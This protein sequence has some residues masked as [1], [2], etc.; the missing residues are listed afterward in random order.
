MIYYFEGGAAMQ[1]KKILCLVLLLAVLLLTGCAVRTAD[2]MYQLPKRS[3]DFNNLQSAIDLAMAGLEYCAPL[4]GENRQT[5]QMADLDGNGDMEYLLFAKGSAERPLR[6]LV[7]DEVM[8]SFQ[9]IDT[10]E[11]MGS[12]FDLV[13]YVQMDDKPGVEMVVGSLLS[14]QVLR[15]VSVY[16]FSHKKAEMLMSANY[17]KFLTIDLDGDDRSE[18]FVLRPGQG[19]TDNGV[20]ELY[21]MEDGTMERSNEVNM[22]EPVDH[23]KRIVI[24]KLYGGEPAVYAASTVGDT[25]LITDVFALR[26]EMLA[27]ISFSNESGTSVQTLRNYYVYADDIDND[28]A[29]ELPY[30]ITMKPLDTQDAADRH[31]LIR[32]YTM[33]SDGSEVNKLYTYHNFVGGWYMELD[34]KWASRIAV[35]RQGNNYAFYLWDRDYENAR[36]VMTVFALTGQNRDMQNSDQDRFVLLKTDSITYAASVEPAAKSYGITQQTVLRSFHLIQQDWKTG[37]T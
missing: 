22:S 4:A 29:I 30:L 8:D 31:D 6:I 2:Q 24:G 23:L 11:S 37:E 9:H 10:I 21:G 36:K 32:W 7:F 3:E 35:Q 18:L 5:V 25:A 19:V 26:N 28:G 12:G 15:S 27:N 34:S 17:T 16:G 13:K 1:Y 33:K 20:A 14:D